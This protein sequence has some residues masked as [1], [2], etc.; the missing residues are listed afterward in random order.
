MHDNLALL[1]RFCEVTKMKFVEKHYAGFPLD[2]KLLHADSSLA[3]VAEI[4]IKNFETHT[5][6]HFMQTIW[7]LEEGLHA[8]KEHKVPYVILCKFKNGDLFYMSDQDHDVERRQPQSDTPMREQRAISGSVFI[9]MHYWAPF[10]Q[11]RFG[12]PAKKV[13]AA[14]VLV[15]IDG[16]QYEEEDL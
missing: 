5:H 7:K 12:A 4:Q 3:A 16:K 8:S 1:T 14:P 6:T 9:P 10:N 2:A 13:K 11:V 15:K